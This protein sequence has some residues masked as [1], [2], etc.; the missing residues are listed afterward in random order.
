MNI[1]QTNELPENDPRHHAL[2]LSAAIK[3]VAAHAREDIAKVDDHNAH[4]IYEM[5]AEVLENAAHRLDV[6]VNDCEQD[7][8]LQQASLG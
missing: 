8:A 5:T 4:L 1:P 3:A 7:I 6:F 2:N